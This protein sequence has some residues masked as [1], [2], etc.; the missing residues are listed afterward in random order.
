MGGRP[1]LYATTG[2]IEYRR[3]LIYGTNGIPLPRNHFAG[4]NTVRTDAQDI[5][6]AVGQARNT[7]D[8]ANILVTSAIR[9]Q[10]DADWAEGT[11]AGGFPDTALNIAADT[12]YHVF[13]LGKADN[14]GFDA[15]F[16][17]AINATNLIND[18]AVVSAGYT[19]YRR[20]G[21]VKTDDAASPEEI[22]DY[23]QRGNQFIPAVTENVVTVSAPADDTGATVVLLGCP[24][25]HS[26]LVEINVILADAATSLI[27]TLITS[28]DQT[29]VNTSPT[30]I[31]LTT[32]TAYG[33]VGAVATHGWWR[34][35]TAGSI[36]HSSWSQSDTIDTVR[37]AVLSW[38][39]D[40]G[41]YD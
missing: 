14:S 7:G 10:I 12:W 15:G 31:S 18:A 19:T 34:T 40:F 29:D 9:K 22:L 3:P 8:T 32:M 28:L 5:T 20:V 11:A 39:D 36:R 27:R 17:S 37:F 1:Q 26:V 23:T 33:D 2:D 30:A 6:I 13:I 4:L 35:D 16:D 41:K 24:I 38:M 25:D 21:S